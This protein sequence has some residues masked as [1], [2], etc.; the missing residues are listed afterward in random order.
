MLRWVNEEAPRIVVAKHCYQALVETMLVG[1]DF[2]CGVEL[3]R[4]EATAWLRGA[5]RLPS[6]T[7]CGGCDQGRSGQGGQGWDG[8]PGDACAGVGAWWGATAGGA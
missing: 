8:Q 3:L 2:L 7:R 5:H 1:G 6:M 4:N